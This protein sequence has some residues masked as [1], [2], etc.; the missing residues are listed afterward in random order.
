M[1]KPYVM[2]LDE[3]TTG[4]RAIIFDKSGCVI[5]DCSREFTQIFPTPGWVEHNAV[6]ILE[7]QIE[8]ARKAINKAK[9]SPEEIR[10]IGVT[11]QR[12]TSVIWDK[13]TGKPIYNAIC[14][15][16]RQTAEI[17]EKWVEDGLTEEIREKTGLVIDAYFSASKIPWILDKIPGAR[18]RAEQGELLFG[19]IDTWLIWNLTGGRSHKTDYSNA[20]RTMLYNIMKMKWDEE[21]CRKM[22]IPMALLPEV[23][24]SNGD[25]GV[26]GASLFGAEIPIRGDA[27]D[28]QAAL[29]GQAC[30]KPGMAKNTFGTAGV[31]VMNTGDKPVLKDGLTTTIAWGIDGKVSYA[32]EGV[33]FI[34]GATIQWLRDEAKIIYTAADTEWYGFMVPDTGGVYLVPAFVGLCAPYWDM[35]ARGMIIGITRGTTRNHLIRAGLEALAYQTKDIIN[36]VIKDGTIEVSELRVDGGA[37]KNSL[38]CQ[39]QADILGIPVIR[40]KITEMTALGAAYLAGL[41]S[42][43]WQSTSEIAAQWGI[44]QT[45]KPEMSAEYRDNL[46]YGWQEAVQLCMGWAK[47]VRV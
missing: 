24:D 13:T 39:F 46:Y 27:G 5:G 17:A 16:S 18:Q 11:N 3:G 21:L 34:S 36:A 29:F 12:E 43:M 45:F 8:V 7:A 4:V 42:G 25:Y 6:E 9:V 31:Y 28:Q 44:D 23:I 40:P 20:S 14:W 32:L 33:I 15:Q 2:A 26:A 41:G 1:E 30:F 35:Y 10:A 38:L 37:V 47:K 22:D 19:T